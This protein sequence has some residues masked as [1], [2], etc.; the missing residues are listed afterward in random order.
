M[1]N[2]LVLAVGL[3]DPLAL[4]NAK[5]GPEPQPRSQPPMTHFRGQPLKTATFGL[6]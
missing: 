5:N 4:I 1:T 6:G 3:V 2:L